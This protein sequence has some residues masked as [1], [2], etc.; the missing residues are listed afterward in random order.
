M[1]T[2][3]KFSSPSKATG[4]LVVQANS[5]DGPHFRLIRCGIN[6]FRVTPPPHAMFMDAME[7]GASWEYVLSGVIYY[8]IGEERYRVEAGQALVTRRPDPGWMLRPVKDAP[9]QTLWLGIA[10]EPAF[11]MFDY[12]HLKYGQ[13]QRLQPNSRAVNLARQ[14][15]RLVAAQPKR[16]AYFWSEKTF[17]WMNAWW[18][19]VQEDHQRL[20]YTELKAIKPSRLISYAPQS[21]KNYA[22]EIGY[23]RAYLSRKLT[24][25]WLRSPGRVLREVR[26]QDAARL[27]RT[28][29][30]SISEVGG[31]V[32]YSSAA[33][34]C[35]AFLRQYHQTPLAYR[36]SHR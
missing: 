4:D 5:W 29:R 30:L 12:L 34:F 28:S 10:G 8:K 14:L 35:R 21:I 23:S 2:N 7:P 36:R 6:D 33:G 31:K 3:L 11:R 17:Q 9:V 19:C 22:S 24:Q 18:Q 15:V 25:Q 1:E 16:S 13:I 20:D 26:L 32:G 27:L